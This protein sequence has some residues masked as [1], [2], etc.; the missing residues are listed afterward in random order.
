MPLLRRHH[1]PRGPQLARL[2][3]LARLPLQFPK[4]RRRRQWQRG[5][6]RETLDPHQ[7]VLDLSRGPK[8]PRRESIVTKIL[9]LSAPVLQWWT[10][11]R[12]SFR[13]GVPD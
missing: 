7:K 3:W 10:R 11:K 12:K 8:D 13:L 4:T 2:Q 9:R 5:P 6:R 1:H